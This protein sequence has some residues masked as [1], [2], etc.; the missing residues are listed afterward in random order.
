LIPGE[1]PEERERF[2]QNFVED[3][4]AA[5]APEAF[6]ARSAAELAGLYQRALG[7]NHAAVRQ[8]IQKVK[9]HFE[10]HGAADADH[11]VERF[12]QDPVHYLRNLLASPL[13]TQAV[14]EQWHRLDREVSKGGMLER[15]DVLLGIRLMGKRPN[16]V[17]TD[18]AVTDWFA[19][20]LVAS[21]DEGTDLI[22]H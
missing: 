13:G 21:L 6:Q 20:G 7:S 10:G 3:L 2:A 14:L 5:T 11:L 19:A 15:S 16:Q 18:P 17:F 12:G 4:G 8:K 22:D 1:S 9:D